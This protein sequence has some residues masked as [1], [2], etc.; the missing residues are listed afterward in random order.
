[1]DRMEQARGRI[2]AAAARRFAEGGFAGAQMAEIARDAGMGVGTLY[3]HFPSKEALYRAMVHRFLSRLFEATESALDAAG[4]SLAEALR[5]YARATVAC[6]AEDPLVCRAVARETLGSRVVF[7]SVIGPDDWER[8][9]AH[10]A[11]VAGV[12]SA[13]HRELGG[14]ISP[15]DAAVFFLG[16]L[17]SFVEHDLNRDAPEA[18]RER[19]ELAVRL[20][21][22][23]VEGGP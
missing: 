7:R 1:M 14:S 11:Q 17:W 15:E 23:G 20:V 4:G 2:L 9:Q 5:A 12:F 16:T 8:I 21:L 18:I 10:R 6:V 19:A 13:H 3:K 22:R